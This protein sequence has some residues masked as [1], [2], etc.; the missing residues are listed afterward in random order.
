MERRCYRLRESTVDAAAKT[1]AWAQAAGQFRRHCAA[2]LS[3]PSIEAGIPN[4]TASGIMEQSAWLDEPPEDQ[5]EH[6]GDDDA[7]RE[8]PERDPRH[9]LPLA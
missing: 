1:L 5:K 2:W 9:P 6:K 7:S 3:L 8:C 4:P